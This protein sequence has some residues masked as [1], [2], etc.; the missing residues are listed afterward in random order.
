MIDDFIDTANIYIN[1]VPMDTRQYNNTFTSS[2]EFNIDISEIIVNTL[3]VTVWYQS[4]LGH[5]STTSIVVY[6]V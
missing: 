3:I 6:L 5:E 4:P 1:G 2:I